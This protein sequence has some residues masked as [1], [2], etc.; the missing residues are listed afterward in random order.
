MTTSRTAKRYVL[1]IVAG[2]LMGALAFVAVH[3]A[4]AA[5][6]ARQAEQAEQAQQAQPVAAAQDVPQ[7]LPG[8]SAE[9][10]AQDDPVE[11]P[12]STTTPTPIVTTTAPAP[13][14]VPI[15]TS[16]EQ[17]PAPIATMPGQVLPTTPPAVTYDVPADP[18][19]IPTAISYD[20]LTCPQ[21][22]SWTVHSPAG[23]PLVMCP[24]SQPL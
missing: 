9:V 4:R 15:V 11:P 12:T 8:G 2:V 10:A 23:M 1:A 13:A 19:P 5:E 6:Q 3:S 22:D 14:P 20:G 21:P 17:P 16:S 18:L 7:V 24:G